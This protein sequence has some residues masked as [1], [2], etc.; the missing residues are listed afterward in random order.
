MM[1]KKMVDFNKS[2][3]DCF[4]TAD[5]M[6]LLAQAGSSV[7][8]N[9]S[10][11]FKKTS[12][13]SQHYWEIYDTGISQQDFNVLLSDHSFFQFHLQESGDIRLAFYPNPYRFIEYQEYQRDAL[14]MLEEQEITQ[15][16]YFQLL[17]EGSFTCDI[18][19]IRYDYSIEQY[20]ENY[21]PAAHLH[22]GF[23]AEN[24]W[25]VRRI[26]TPHAFMLKILRNYYLKTW[27][28]TSGEII[29]PDDD[30]LDKRYRNEVAQCKKLK[31]HHF[32]SFEG[33]RLHIL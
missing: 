7:S 4:E 29:N 3:R 20:C 6:G 22:I 18:P 1:V 9:A 13:R 10:D 26:L 2:I 19:A 24:R 33:Q 25:P 11:K 16:E 12:L 15:E 31:T 32:S 8:L 27:I 23:Y 14:Q 28:K 5:V 17:S 21:H 30:F